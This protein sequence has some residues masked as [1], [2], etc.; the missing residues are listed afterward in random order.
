MKIPVLL[1]CSMVA[2]TCAV[3]VKR[4][5]RF[6][7]HFIFGTSTAAHQIEGAWDADDKSESI[8]DYLTHNNPG[9]ISDQSNGD[10][11]CDSYHKYKRDVEMMRELGI[12]SYRF[13]VVWSRILPNGLA[14]R[15]SE[16][17]IAYYNNVIDEVLKYNIQPMITLYHWD[18]PQK[19]QDMGG[20]LNP[21]IVDWFADYAR[22]V[23]DN[24][25]DRVKTFITF[26]EAAQV[27]HDGYGSVTKALM[28]N[29]TDVGEFIC[30]K[31]LILAHAKAYHVYNDEFKPVRGGSCGFAIAVGAA[32][33]G[34]AIQS[35]W[36]LPAGP[37]PARAPPQAWV[38]RHAA[39]SAQGG[40]GAAQRAP[41]ATVARVHVS[42][43]KQ[44]SDSQSDEENDEDVLDLDQAAKD[45][46]C[47]SR[48]GLDYSLFISVFFD[49]IPSPW[50]SLGPRDCDQP[51]GPFRPSPT[52]GAAQPIVDSEEV[53]HAVELFN[54]FQQMPKSLYIALNE[55]Q[56]R[57]GDIPIYVTENGWSTREGIEDDERVDYYRDAL[58]DVL[59]ALDE[60]ID[61][62]G[63]YA[64]SLMDNFEWLAG[65]TKSFGFYEI[66]FAD[67]ELTRIPRKSAFIY[68]QI[69][70]T[71]EIVYDYQPES[72]VMSIDA[73]H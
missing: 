46:M 24:F 65:Y 3:E 38:E 70:K 49:S 73:G 18:L 66:N 28:L 42:Q 43:H 14:D 36:H 41:C 54:Q 29:I 32:S 35:R 10:T 12:D 1:L 57:Y 20:F 63:Y 51:P 19:L 22:V 47:F 31:N 7:K 6:P 72:Y 5:R 26:N 34:L 60:G 59:D 48:S 27:C 62:R 11:A 30:A 9:A 39:T 55:I 2:V 45:A 21:L 67:P 50:S 40:G 71:R 64:W 8:W 17:G 16:A 15:V 53:L 37:Q 56:K 68:K 13:S 58:E 25:G 4:S 52:L 44:D 33:V 61:V 23:F 69:I